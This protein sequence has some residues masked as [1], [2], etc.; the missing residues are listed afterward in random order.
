MEKELFQST[1]LDKAKAANN[2]AP[3]DN[4]SERTI[5]EVVALFLPSFADDE[6]ITDE[7]WNLP[8]QMVKTLSG[9]LRHDTS[10]GIN[11]FKTKYAEEQKTANQKAIDDAV[12]AFKEQWEKDHPS[13]QQQ[14]QQQQQPDIAKLVAE[15]VAEQMKG[16]TGEN[17]EFG[18]LS[19]QFGD[20][21]KMQ[22]EQ[23][24]ANAIANVRNQVKE[25]LL[26]RGVEEDDYAL[27]IT[28]EKLTIGEN[29]DVAAL[30]TQA[31]KDY[32]AIFKRMHKDDGAIPPFAGGQGKG[33]LPPFIQSHID[34]A[35]QEAKDAQEYANSIQF[36]K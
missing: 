6:K 27:E 3:I 2:N 23:T 20:F 15:Q 14:Q 16:L 21:L 29:P 19:K 5:N 7:S 34:R 35:A 22:E 10:L 32:E 36:A 24:K 17:S 31:E 28:L 30:K 1:L 4:L 25:Y 13:Q 18:K 8:V 9:Q 26:G 11:D 33:K 12:A